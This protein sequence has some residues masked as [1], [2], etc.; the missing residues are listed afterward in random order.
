MAGAAQRIANRVLVRVAGGPLRAYSLVVHTGRSSGRV[1][2]NPVSAYPLGD[3][4]VLPVLYGEDSNW[5]RNALAGG[6][7]LRTR[8]VDHRLERVAVIG[9]AQA[10]PAFPR[11][12]RALLR[13]R[14]IEAF[15]WGRPAA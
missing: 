6:L 5:V 3:G 15:V 2:R 10:L 1:Y 8:G 12:Q 9:A 4:F 7:T 13:A 11:Y 14:G